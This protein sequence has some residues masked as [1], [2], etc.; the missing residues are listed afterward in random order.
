MA[1]VLESYLLQVID[2][3][4]PVKGAVP[5]V[6]RG[7]LGG[8]ARLYDAGLESY[9]A[10]ETMG[11]RKRERLPIPVVS[12]GNLT[13]GGTGKTPMTVKLCGKL[14]EKG[15]RLAILSRGHG[16]S[17]QE[18]RVVSDTEGRMLLSPRDAGDEPVM[19]ARSCSKIP[20]IV[21]KDRY[22]SGRE[23]LR[24]WPLDLLVLDDGFQYWQLARDLDIVL[25]DS[26]LPFDNGYP[27]P[28]GLLREPKRHLSRGHIAVITRADRLDA[29]GKTAIIEEIHAIKPNMPIFFAS[30]KPIS[31]IPVTGSSDP[32][33]LSALFD[34]PIVA[35]SG[36]AQPQ[37]FLDTLKSAGYR[38]AGSLKYDD[39]HNYTVED[40]KTATDTA[41]GSGAEAIVMTEKDSVKWP[42]YE[43]KIPI[44]ALRIE[45]SIEKEAELINSILTIDME[46]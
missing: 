8:A 33:P 19:L 17:S 5:S 34:K 23:A 39:H 26:V 16:G 45:M 28:R 14:R 44:Y 10:A 3:R 15:V 4:R 21:G 32:A 1:S 13:V 11:I 25:L 40:I 37:S 2:A 30:H 29:A 6:L 35:L 31:L 42:E 24:R 38:I 46:S 43:T 20:V 22:Q 12:I 18:T 27:L 41:E 7:F 9:L 36:I